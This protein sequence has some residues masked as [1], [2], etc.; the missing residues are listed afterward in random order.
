MPFL[1]NIPDANA[2][3]ADDEQAM[4]ADLDFKFNDV[5]SRDEQL[6]SQTEAERVKLR[7]FKLEL[8]RK[9]FIT[10]Q[11]LGVDPNDTESISRFL[12]RLEQQDPDLVTLFQTALEGLVPTEES[13]VPE[14]E[15]SSGGL[16]SKFTNLQKNILQGRK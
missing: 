3:P 2:V 13:S 5:K 8:L 12:Q 7:K 10:L 16:M 14:S 11:D 1:N 4:R 6:R 15:P 9:V